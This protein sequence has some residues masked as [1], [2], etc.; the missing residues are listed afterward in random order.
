MYSTNYDICAFLCVCV[1]QW[2]YKFFFST[3][4]KIFIFF[5]SLL[6]TYLPWT[7]C[8]HTDVLAKGALLYLVDKLGQ[9]GM[10]AA[11]VVNLQICIWTQFHIRRMSDAHNYNN[12]LVINISIHPSNPFNS[13]SYNVKFHT[14]VT[15]SSTSSSSSSFSAPKN[16]RMQAKKSFVNFRLSFGLFINFTH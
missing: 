7:Q 14:L 10:S 5:Q 11:A 16:L 15:C 3:V 1:Y 4:E 12:V 8:D 13:Y 6:G 2:L 9:L